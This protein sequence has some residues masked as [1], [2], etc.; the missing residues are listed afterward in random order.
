MLAATASDSGEV[1]EL[2]GVEVATSERLVDRQRVLVGLDCT[3]VVAHRLVD[4]GDCVEDLALVDLVAGPAVDLG[5][6]ESLF[7]RRRKAAGLVVDDTEQVMR[8]GQSQRRPTVGA[9]LDYFGGERERVVGVAAL[10]RD[11]CK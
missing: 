9:E 6:C 4:D 2:H 8:P 5:C 1:A 7:E 11:R 10:V 3:A